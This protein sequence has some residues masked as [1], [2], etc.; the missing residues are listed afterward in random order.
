MTE[1][2]TMEEMITGMNCCLGHVGCDCKTAPWPWQGE[3]GNAWADVRHSMH[4]NV[5]D[6]WAETRSSFERP[7]LA[8]ED[9]PFALMVWESERILKET[10]SSLARIKRMLYRPSVLE[11][12]MVTPP[13][14]FGT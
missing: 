14:S 6:P 8:S 2:M 7:P 1:D 13:G 12:A 10:T 9:D 4:G 11:Q 3:N 5:T